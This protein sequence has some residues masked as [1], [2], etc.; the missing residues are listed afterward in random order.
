MTY[1]WAQYER[2][3]F[4]DLCRFLVDN[5]R[6]LT[7]VT[8]LLACHVGAIVF[9][10]SPKNDPRPPKTTVWEATSLYDDDVY[11]IQGNF[12]RNKSFLAEPRPLRK[13]ELLKLLI[14]IKAWRI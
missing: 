10:F 12:N 1:L 13:T 5:S 11:L 4:F 7:S 9:H 14:E 8:F 3:C 6:K 2:K